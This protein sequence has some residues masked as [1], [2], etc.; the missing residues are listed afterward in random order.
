PSPR[1]T[2]FGPVGESGSGKSTGARMM[3]GLLQPTSGTVRLD[4]VDIW[5]GREARA[6]RRQR[7]QMIFQDP[8]AS[9]NPRWRVR[10]IVAEPMRALGLAGGRGETD[11]RVA[12]LL[13]R[14]RLDPDAMRKYPHEFSG[15]Q[16]QRIAIARALASR[17][18]FIICDEPTSALD[19]SVQAQVLELMT[20]LQ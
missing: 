13:E 15:G 4:G 14:V 8:Y 10:D 5:G 16:R 19:V 18:E 1:G 20:T 12:D 2:T 3:V 9:L 17:P 7:I 6:E 11:E